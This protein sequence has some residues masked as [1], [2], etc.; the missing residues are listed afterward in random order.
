M[1]PE[2][3]NQIY[4]ISHSLASGSIET[5]PALVNSSINKFKRD[6]KFLLLL[7]GDG[8][9]DGSRRPLAGYGNPKRGENRTK[10]IG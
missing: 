3:L 5:H 9:G 6:S 4:R 8:D 10:G 7:P 2:V 1:V